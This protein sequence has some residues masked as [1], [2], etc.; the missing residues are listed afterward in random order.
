[1]WK[2]KTLL[3]VKLI[4]AERKIAR[5]NFLQIET[6]RADNNDLVFLLKKELWTHLNYQKQQWIIE[7]VWLHAVRMDVRKNVCISVW[8][9]WT[10]IHPRPMSK[11][12]Q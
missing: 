9:C 8:S 3:L 2:A 6:S 12:Y 4:L 10:A 7:P 1:M 11:K 5:N